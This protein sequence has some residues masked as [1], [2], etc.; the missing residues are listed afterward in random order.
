MKASFLCAVA[1]AAA[2]ALP[3]PAQAQGP[4]VLPVFMKTSN[5]SMAPAIPAGTVIVQEPVGATPL[6]AGD[7]VLV[8]NP[9]DRNTL[10]PLRVAALGGGRVELDEGAVMVD[11][12]RVA[13]LPVPF[14]GPRPPWPGLDAD[15]D[16]P[17]AQRVPRVPHGLAFVLGD[18]PVSL[19]S[20]SFG[21]VPPDAV[22]GRIH[23]WAEVAKDK[24]AARPYLQRN[25]DALTPR[26][27]LKVEEGLTL[28]TV[29]LG[30][31]N[32]VELYVKFDI[33][34][35]GPLP[36]PEPLLGP[37]RTALT[38]VYCRS[39]LGQYTQGVSARYL[40]SDREKDIAVIAV[41][42][43]ACAR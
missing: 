30:A 28:T 23:T 42:G 18:N 22:V 3:T 8:R 26:L 39:A 34:Y 1:S 37:L 5:D 2:L 6:A 11:G 31:D 19:D 21:P 24:A 43:T 10:F 16:K 32:E 20:R 9:R 33:A 14:A 13:G 27:P 17:G 15:A 41:P 38:Q 35:A 36:M 25:I 40:L 7:L 12:K 29:L 4:Y